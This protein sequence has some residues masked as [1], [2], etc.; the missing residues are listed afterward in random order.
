[1]SDRQQQ[2][3]QVEHHRALQRKLNH[4]DATD[5]STRGHNT[6]VIKPE[7]LEDPELRRHYRAWRQ[8]LALESE[9]PDWRSQT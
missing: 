9:L 7:D 3:A 2:R 1:M 5:P 4:K 8:A 6:R